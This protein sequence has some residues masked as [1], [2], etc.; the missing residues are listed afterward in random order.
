M[1][2]T[3]CEIEGQHVGPSWWEHDAQGIS[4]CR[5]CDECRTER[6]SHYRL[7]ILT[8]YNQSDVDE[9]IEAEE[10][11]YEEAPWEID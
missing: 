7:E 4:L 11:G 3:R 10:P 5:V 2:A 6:L 9:P 1:S 8:G